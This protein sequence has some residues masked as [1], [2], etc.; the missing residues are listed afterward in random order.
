MA[1]RL[2]IYD[3]S[4][5]LVVAMGHRLY[6]VLTLTTVG[7]ATSGTLSDSRVIASN[8]VVG[9]LTG[10]GTSGYK[11]PTITRNNSLNRYEWNYGSIPV[12]ERDPSL[13]LTLRMY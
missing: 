11:N 5:N 8:N 12:G 3:A 7:T 9:V 2:E 13:K 1:A 10:A 6:K 4:G